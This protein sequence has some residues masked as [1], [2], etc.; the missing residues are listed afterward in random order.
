[1]VVDNDSEDPQ[2]QQ[3]PFVTETQAP[4][5]WG[6]R[7]SNGEYDEARFWLLDHLFEMHGAPDNN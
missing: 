6:G 7:N 5:W 1:M 3:G 4:E 2:R